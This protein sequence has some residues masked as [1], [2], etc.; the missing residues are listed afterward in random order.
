MR[1]TI[2]AMDAPAFDRRAEPSEDWLPLA[3]APLSIQAVPPDEKG[4]AP[5]LLSREEI[6]SFLRERLVGGRIGNC[7]I[8]FEHGLVGL[9]WHPYWDEEEENSYDIELLT[10]DAIAGWRPDDGPLTNLGNFL[11]HSDEVWPEMEYRF[12]TALWLRRWTIVGRIE[13]SY[14]PRFTE[15][16]LRDFLAL[17]ILDWVRGIGENEFGERVYAIHVVEMQSRLKEIKKE[18]TGSKRRAAVARVIYHVLEG[19]KIKALS[20]T[21]VAAVRSAILSGQITYTCRIALT[22]ACLEN[23]EFCIAYQ[24]VDAGIALANRLRAVSPPTEILRELG[25]KD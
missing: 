24:T 9:Y 22:R 4:V 25:L 14:N 20:E 13:S 3:A 7:E 12:H 17:R 10:L 1:T 6:E 15:I 5:R 19:K 8:D 21:E 23:T 16:G 11:A 2:T 18:W